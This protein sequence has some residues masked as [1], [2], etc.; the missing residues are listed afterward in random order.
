[1]ERHSF[2]SPV[3]A[4]V[5]ALMMA[6][7]P[8]LDGAQI[9]QAMFAT[10]VDLGAAGRDPYYGYGRVNAAAGVKAAVAKVTVADTQAPTSSITS[11]AASSS[12]SGTVTVAVN[13]TDNVG[14]DRVELKANGT[15]V[16]IDSA[17]PFSFSWNSTGVPNGMNTLVATAYDKAGNAT[18]SSPVSVSVANATPPVVTD[19]TP[20]VVTIDNPVSGTVSGTVSIS[21]HATDNSGAAALT[22]SIYIDN[23]LVAN[24]KGGTLAYTWH[25]RRYM[26]GNHAV[27]VVAKDAAG[28]WSSATVLV[29]V[30]R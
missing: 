18:A 8:A 17:S 3:A 30:V 23:A 22:Q 12:V 2:A 27:K 14:V 15:V 1:V 5:A 19:T 29:T 28:N 24:G 9:E 10:A 11:P 25:T 26:T 6:A 21:V 16:G 7:A 13:A 4:G 20:P